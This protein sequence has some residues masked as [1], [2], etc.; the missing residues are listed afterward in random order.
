LN[1]ALNIHKSINSN[2]IFEVFC[3]FGVLEFLKGNLEEARIY[4]KKAQETVPQSLSLD[5]I[6]LQLNSLIIDLNSKEISL[7]RVHQEIWEIYNNP[8]ITK[9]PWVRFQVVYNLYNLELVLNLSITEHPRE[10][11]IDKN[12]KR[13]TTCFEVLVKVHLDGLDLPMS[14]SLSPNWRY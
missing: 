4:T 8:V 2:E 10:Y 5:H 7:L 11:Y 9:D 3:N 14:L 12:H 6:I 1:E 13:N